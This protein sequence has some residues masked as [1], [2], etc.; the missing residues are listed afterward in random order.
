MTC[1]CVNA[2]LGHQKSV[3]CDIIVIEKIDE[4]RINRLTLDRPS[5]WTGMSIVT[6]RP[7]LHHGAAL[8]KGRSC[9]TRDWGHSSA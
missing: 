3:F 9:C 8:Q 4:P 2:G 5:T 7:T 6:S 1:I